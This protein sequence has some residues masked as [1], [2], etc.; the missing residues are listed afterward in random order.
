MSSPRTTRRPTAQRQ[1]ELTSAALE[2][3][4]T[5]GI[6]ALTTRALAAHVGITGGAIF[7]HFPTLDALLDAVVARVE[8]LLAGTLPDEA[9]PPRERLAR[10]VEARSTAVGSQVGVLQLVSSEQFQLALPPAA[11]ARLQKCVDQTRAYVVGALRA[12]Q[13]DGS[14]RDDIDAKSLAVIVLGTTRLLAM[15]RG[16]A[17]PR[18]VRKA[19]VTLLEPPPPARPR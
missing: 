14:I 10:F 5:R 7:R 19:L 15:K 12:G 9:L 18:A 4:A 2:L 16:G 17:D 8:T 13:T 11:V 1:D 6:S 3:I